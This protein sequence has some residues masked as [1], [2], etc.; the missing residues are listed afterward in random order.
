MIKLIPIL[1]EKC[2]VEIL[3]KM[4]EERT[5]EQSISHKGMPTMD[6]H[7]KF[8]FSKPY[9]AWYFIRNEHDEIVGNIYLTDRR[10]IGIMIF[11]AHSGKGYGTKAVRELMKTW[12]GQFYANVNPDNKPSVEFFKGLGG[13][14]VQ[15]TYKLTG[16]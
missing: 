10:E 12:P 4:L 1:Q 3:Y 8:V 9:F 11:K 15:H 5:P 6:E 14:L 16:E 7:Q 2:A 13:K